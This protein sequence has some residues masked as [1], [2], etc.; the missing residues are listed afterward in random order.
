MK[1]A[2]MQPYFLKKNKIIARKSIV[3]ASNIKKDD[4]FDENNITIK[5]PGNGI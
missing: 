2:I 4:I 1:I 3:A 5:R